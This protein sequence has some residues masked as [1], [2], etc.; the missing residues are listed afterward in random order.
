ML[1]IAISGKANSGKNTLTNFIIKEL[2]TELEPWKFKV[3]AFA[4]PIKRM[5][6]EMFP[7]C[8]E[9]ALYGSSKLRQNKISSILDQYAAHQL[10]ATYR[11]ASVDI[12][13]LGR[14]YHSNFWIWHAQLELD[15]IRKNH[16][17]IQAFI[18]SD[19]RFPN[20]LEW[21]KSENFI[22]CRIKRNTG[23]QIDDISETIQD[24]I[25]DDVFDFI[26]DNNSSIEH[27]KNQGNQI[28]R[29]IRH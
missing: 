5:I 25:P 22:L 6:Q 24:S 27:L 4:D 2:D 23:T 21:L 12:G 9:E 16:P 7:Q 14:N 8:S 26:I 11:Q 29:S 3:V 19:L 13:K 18:V 20:E 15:R 28:V 10:N 17:E 1:K